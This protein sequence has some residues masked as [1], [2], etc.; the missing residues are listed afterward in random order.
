MNA[1]LN[2]EENRLDI[3]DITVCAVCCCSS[4]SSLQTVAILSRKPLT[5]VL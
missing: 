1:F 5:T 4:L 3:L 2:K